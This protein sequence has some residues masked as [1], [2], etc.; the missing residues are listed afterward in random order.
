[1]KTDLLKDLKD[2]AQNY[3]NDELSYIEYNNKYN[4]KLVFKT[5][6]YAKQFINENE[7]LANSKNELIFWPIK[8]EQNDKS[9]HLTVC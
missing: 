8:F 3:F 6:E 4:I 5:Y 9:V 2:R 1:M 7:K